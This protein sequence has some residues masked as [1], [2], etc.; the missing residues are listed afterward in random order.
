MSC[1]YFS[2]K[3]KCFLDMMWKVTGKDFHLDNQ[4]FS[5]PIPSCLW[6]TQLVC[7]FGKF[8]KS[9]LRS[10]EIYFFNHNL[11]KAKSL[12]SLCATLRQQLTWRV[13]KM[14]RK[15]CN[16]Y[17]TVSLDFSIFRGFWLFEI[18]F[19]SNFDYFFL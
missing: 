9:D 13:L 2:N 15:E 14:Y 19:S 12:N 6:Q 1:Q 16:K 8:N 17:F 7:C 18:K 5:L 11:F 10:R 3:I 4:Y